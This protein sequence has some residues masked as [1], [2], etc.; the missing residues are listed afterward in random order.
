MLNANWITTDYSVGGS[1]PLFCRFFS[2]KKSVKRATLKISARGVYEATL[3]GNRVG[4][5]I[6]APGWTSYRDHIQVQEYNVSDMLTDEN[7]LIL[8]LANGWYGDRAKM[9]DTAVIAELTI[10]YAD[11]TAET[12]ATD[13]SWRVAQSGLTFCSHYD[14][15]I[16][17][18]RIIPQFDKNAVIS[19]NND[20]SVLV[21]QICEPVTEHERIKPVDVIITPKG[22]TVLDF[23]QNLTGALEITLDSK[24]GDKVSFSFAEVLDKDGNFYNENYRDARA[25]YE[26][27]CKDGI[28]TYKPTL[29]FYGFRYVRINEYPVELKPENFTAVVMHTDMK[30]TGYIKTSDPMIN[31]LFSNIV[32][33]QKGNFFDV[34]TD[35]PQRD[36]RWGWTGDAQVFIKTACYN[37]DAHKF[38]LKWLADLKFGQQPNGAV[39]EIVPAL[40]VGRVSAGW[41]DCVTVCPWEIYLTYGDAEILEKMFEPMQRWVDY[42]SAV[43]TKPFLWFGGNQYGDWLELKC[44]SGEFKGKTRDDLVAS[45]F[46]A[47]SV[48]IL[49]KAGRVIGR[50]VTEY[51]RLYKKIVTAFNDEFKDEFIT[52]TEHILPLQFGLCSDKD[53]VARSLVDIIH[54]DGDILQ[55]GFLG[56]PYILHVLSDNGYAELAYK[57]LLRKDYPSWLYPISKGATTVWEHWDG[58]RPDGTFWPAKMNSFNHYAYGSVGDWMYGVMGGINP[59]PEKAG[60]KELLYKPIATDYIDSFEAEFD[61]PNGKIISKWRHENGNT[62][63]ELVTPVKTHAIVDGRKYILEKGC[64]RF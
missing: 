11:E 45:A 37:F 47:N 34:P 5:F 43:T 15:I 61:S 25:L 57:L 19:Q 1:C 49:C 46:Y 26:Y 17:D 24:A 63:Y 51:E 35:C 62:V 36:E 2:I 14:G 21:N 39:P 30:R 60:Y 9:K 4:N 20:I 58:I 41:A 50:D 12:V 16:F 44:E 22:E 33:S 55:T 59:I 29:T 18:A 6:M 31:Q 56:T 42:I 52:Q 28:Q 27:I 10:M 23:G 48:D 3:N 32:W 40:R 7:Q 64:H 38:Y 53:A 13:E 54:S 8:Q